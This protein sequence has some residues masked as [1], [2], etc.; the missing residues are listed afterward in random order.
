MHSLSICYH[1]QFVLECRTL[2]VMSD[3]QSNVQMRCVEDELGMYEKNECLNVYFVEL[4]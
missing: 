2:V 4:L 3:V 1:T